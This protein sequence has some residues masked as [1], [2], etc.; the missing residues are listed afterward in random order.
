MTAAAPEV[1]AVVVTHGSL[2]QELVRTAET[3]L[4]PQDRVEVISNTDA[5][6]ER[7]ADGLLARLASEPDVSVY[8]FVD[9][10][11]GSCGILCREVRR[12]R[13]DAVVFSGVNLPMLVE[14]FHWRG[15]VAETELRQRLIGK[16]RDGIQCI[17]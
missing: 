5:T 12:R 7:I 17:G 8:L 2:G 6:P 15:R 11:G 14:F 13:P 16:G 4:G 10:L 1:F 3:I 9:L